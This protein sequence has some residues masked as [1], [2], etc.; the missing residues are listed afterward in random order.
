MPRRNQKH[1]HSLTVNGKPTHSRTYRIWSGI[2][3]R[4]ANPRCKAYPNYGGRG[5]TLCDRWRR[6]FR[7]FLAD[8]G[9]APEGLTIERVDN[10]LGYLKSNCTWVSLQDQQRNRR[11]N[12]PIT[13][14]G[15]TRLLSD[16]ADEVG[17]KR[18]VITY[19]LGAGWPAERAL[20]WPSKRGN[21]GAT[22]HEA[23]AQGRGDAQGRR[24][25]GG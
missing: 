9:E 12:R 4:C 19:R 3:Q 18:V 23:K 24:Q 1:G 7:A 14:F 6:D 13:A 22:T 8:M 11:S 21:N 17:I 25:E 5:I 2:V 20:T 16:W 10:D 15:R